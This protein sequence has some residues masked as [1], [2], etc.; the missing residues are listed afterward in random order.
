MSSQPSWGLA[1]LAS[2]HG[3]GSTGES[4]GVTAA[5]GREQTS[6]KQVWGS[7][8]S[9]LQRRDLLPGAPLRRLSQGG[10]Q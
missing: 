5:E 3:T 9:D 8:V 6:S 10:G 7:E 2:S 4:L 1:S